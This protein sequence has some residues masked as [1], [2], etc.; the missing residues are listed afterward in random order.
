MDTLSTITIMPSTKQEMDNFYMK[1][2]NEILSG[3]ENPLKLLRQLKAI[4]KVVGDLLKDKD[5][6]DE[7]LIEAEKYGQKQIEEYGVTFEVKEVGTKYDYNVTGDS[8]WQE[9]KEKEEQIKQQRQ[10]RE[11]QLKAHNKE[12]VDADTGE[13][14]NPPVKTSKT[15]VTVKF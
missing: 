9:L 11:K 15:K 6:E 2:K 7:I 5:V 4:E 14:I 1:A 12:W 10:E 3:N 8:T 13:V